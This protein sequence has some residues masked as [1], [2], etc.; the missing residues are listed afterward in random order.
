MLQGY[1]PSPFVKPT[2]PI[3]KTNMKVLTIDLSFVFF[4]V[5]KH[6]VRNNIWPPRGHTN[7]L[8]VDSFVVIMQLSCQFMI[9]WKKILMSP[10]DIDHYFNDKLSAKIPN[11]EA[12][13]V[14]LN[15]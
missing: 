15:K 3:S 8:I 9:S 14:P 6:I 4:R 12:L 7:R 5:V 2:E 10:A 1:K 13:E 11:F